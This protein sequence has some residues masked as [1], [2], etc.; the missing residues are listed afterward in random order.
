MDSDDGHDDESHLDSSLMTMMGTKSER[1]GATSRCGC[2]GSG[3]HGAMK[4]TS[5][6]QPV[7]EAIAL[8]GPGRLQPEFNTLVKTIT[9]RFCMEMRQ[10]GLDPLPIT[11]RRRTVR[12][13]ANLILQKT[14]SRPGFL[15][16]RSI[17]E[18][19]ASTDDGEARNGR[20]LVNGLSSP[21]LRVR[22]TMSG[23]TTLRSAGDVRSFSL[24]QGRTL[25]KVNTLTGPVHLATEDNQVTTVDQLAGEMSLV[26]H[27]RGGGVTLHSFRFD[28][29]V[30]DVRSAPSSE[31]ASSTSFRSAPAV[32]LQH[33]MD[34]GLGDDQSAGGNGMEA[35]VTRLLRRALRFVLNAAR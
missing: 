7:P 2:C 11:L 8:Q 19:T 12:E 33:L 26:L 30:V 14:N 23:L 5:N 16:K 24:S 15:F 4:V 28:K 32:D 25:L 17:V 29:P 13:T 18:E 22:T 31:P 9:D 3:L 20:G 6:Q 1:V 21:V 10:L 27:P 34:S 35:A